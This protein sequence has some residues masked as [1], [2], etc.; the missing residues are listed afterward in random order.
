VNRDNRIKA[1]PPPLADGV[2]SSSIAA[3]TGSNFRWSSFVFNSCQQAFTLL[4]VMVAVAFIGIALL[5]LLA[6]HHSALQSVARTRGLTQAALLAQALM[7]DAEQ[8]R[9]PEPGRLSGNFQKLYPGQYPNFRWQRIV[10][11]STQFPDI[12]RVRITVF[13]G[14]GFRHTFVL[15]EFMHNPLPQLM[16]PP[17]ALNPQSAPMQSGGGGQ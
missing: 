7:A 13:Y 16:L 5:A 4:E 8:T 10:E 11:P 15:T 9:F 3:G 17:G 6:L 14:P 1:D 12:R 2:C